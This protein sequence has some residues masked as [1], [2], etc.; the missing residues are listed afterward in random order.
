[1]AH[2]TFNGVSDADM[3][4]ITTDI[5]RSV[6]PPVK[7][8]TIEVAGMPGAY[9]MQATLQERIIEIDVVWNSTSCADAVTDTRTLAGY[10]YSATPLELT[11]VDDPNIV[12]YAQLDGATD[13]EAMVY[14]R[15]GTIRFACS[16]PYA[17]SS[18]ETAAVLSP[19]GETVVT[20]TGG[21]ETYPVIDVVVAAPITFLDVVC[22][23]QQFRIGRA[24]GT[25]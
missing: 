23:N 18:T 12:Y 24:E 7:R 19:E 17:Y 8:S 10:L 25:L 3:G 1:M 6:A 5:R 14:V 11:F 16:D 2:W 9:T 13:L 15:R 22:N 21:V 20:N 4:L